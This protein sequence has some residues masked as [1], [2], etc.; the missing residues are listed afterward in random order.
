MLFSPL[1]RYNSCYKTI[2]WHIQNIYSNIISSPTCFDRLALWNTQY[3]VVRILTSHRAYHYILY[4]NWAEILLWNNVFYHNKCI[5]FYQVLNTGLAL[6]RWQ[7]MEINHSDHQNSVQNK[8]SP[9]SSCREMKDEAQ[10][11]SI[12]GSLL[13]LLYTRGCWYILSP[14]RK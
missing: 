3:C 4:S 13:L 1:M 6:W 5:I 7:F 14:T 12:F 10:Q 2:S 9:M 11:G 8:C